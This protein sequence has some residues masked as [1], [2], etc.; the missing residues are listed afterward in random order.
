MEVPDMPYSTCNRR[1]R[2]AAA[3]AV[4][5]CA[6][7]SVSASALADTTVPGDTPVPAIGAITANTTAASS[8]E[9]MAPALTQPFTSWKD[10]RHY[11]LAPGGDF[12]DPSNGGW[13]LDGGAQIVNDASPDGTTDSVLSLPTGAVAVSPTMCVDLDYPSARVWVRNVVGDG[14]VN[15]SVIYDAGK[16]A[17][18]PHAVGN[19]H[20]NKQKT[21]GLS[22]DVKIQ[23]QLAGK[24]AGWRRVAFVLIAGGK[25][26]E[27]RIDDFSVDPRMVR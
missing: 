20:G 27:F 1:S 10:N 21:W 13:K 14:N 25:S 7:L 23:P 11:V 4:T 19:F 18:V 12:S 16:S 24:Q 3:L 8:A 2:L 15:V 6:A 5:A 17:Q 26:S 22:N 9:C